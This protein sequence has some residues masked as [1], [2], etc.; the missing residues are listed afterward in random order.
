MATATDLEVVQGETKVFS[1]TWTV[2]D[3]PKPLTGDNHNYAAHL[4]VRRRRSG[5]FTGTPII[6]VSSLDEITPPIVTLEPGG[7][8]GK[9]K[10][11]IHGGLTALIKRTCEYDL[12]VINQDDTTE[13]VRLIFGQV[14]VSKSVTDNSALVV[15]I[16]TD[17][18]DL[19]P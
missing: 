17:T 4:Q 10:V 5:S 18:E 6:D 11:R 7:D 8:V 19:G 16:E 1:A 3:V 12:W 2:L 13:R 9:V 15:E 14:V